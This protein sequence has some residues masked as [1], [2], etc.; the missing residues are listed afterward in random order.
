MGVDTSDR[1]E[2]LGQF[3]AAYAEFRD[4]A[5][6]RRGWGLWTGSGR[7]L[8][9]PFNAAGVARRYRLLLAVAF[10]VGVVLTLVGGTVGQLGAA[11]VIGSIFAF[12]S[13]MAQAWGLSREAEFKVE[14]DLLFAIERARL[15]PYADR[16]LELERQLRAL[17]P[18]QPHLRRAGSAS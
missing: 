2:L 11:L 9:G 1:D 5:S 15:A 17:P 6:H 4:Q 13:W 7:P 12:G 14:D 3:R 16:V 18:E 10:V 8:I